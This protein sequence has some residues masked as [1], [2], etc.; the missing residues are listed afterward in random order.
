MYI[1]LEVPHRGQ[2]E[3]YH[4]TNKADMLGAYGY[5]LGG[6]NIATINQLKGLA[7][8]QYSDFRVYRSLSAAKKDLNKLESWPA[9]SLKGVDALK[10]V[11][12]FAEQQ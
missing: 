12:V 10:E 1:V 7:D 8:D 4:F 9:H 6:V 11:L 3:A 2:P 5:Q